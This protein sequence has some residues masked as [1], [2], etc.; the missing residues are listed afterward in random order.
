M[1]KT[2]QP[3]MANYV[4]IFEVTDINPKFLLFKYVN[5]LSLV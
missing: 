4:K 3:K 5:M 2:H 1:I